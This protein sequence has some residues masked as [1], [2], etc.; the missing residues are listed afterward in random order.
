MTSTTRLSLFMVI[1]YSLPYFRY[2][3]FF[4]KASIP[5]SKLPGERH[6]LRLFVY[7]T[8]ETETQYSRM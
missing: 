7:G 3:P 8:P 4:K 6:V 1:R 2:F 5:P